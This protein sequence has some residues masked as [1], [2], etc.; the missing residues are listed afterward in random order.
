MMAYN[1]G[2]LMF[3]PCHNQFGCYYRSVLLELANVRKT[4]VDIAKVYTAT[5]PIDLSLLMCC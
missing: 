4:N 2:Q 1:Q 5:V 3:F